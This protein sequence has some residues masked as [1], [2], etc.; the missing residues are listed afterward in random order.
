MLQGYL[1]PILLAQQSPKDRSLLLS[2][3]MAGDVVGD[4]EEH[5]WVKL[6]VETRVRRL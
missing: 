6:N 5:Q 4:G 3:G 2:C 1:S